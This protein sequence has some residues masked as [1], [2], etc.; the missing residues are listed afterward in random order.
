[1]TRLP[2]LA[3]V[4]AALAAGSMMPAQADE[5]R[6]TPAQQAACKPNVF[7]FCAGEIPDVRAI[8]A[9]L[10]RN[11]SRLTPDCQAVFAAA[12]QQQR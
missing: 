4:L 5:Y 2:M 9:C 3:I 8:T 1:M 11:L 7:R 10:R 12:Q 6:G